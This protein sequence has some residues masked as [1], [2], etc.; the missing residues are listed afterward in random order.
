MPQGVQTP[1]FETITKKRLRDASKAVRALSHDGLRF[2]PDALH[3][4]RVALRRMRSVCKNFDAEHRILHKKTTRRIRRLAHT[5]NRARDMDIT[6]DWVQNT[7][8]RLTKRD[9]A[10]ADFLLAYL[11][12]EQQTIQMELQDTLQPYFKKLKKRVLHD[13]NSKRSRHQLSPA[14][15]ASRTEELLAEIKQGVMLYHKEYSSSSRATDKCIETLHQTRIV[16]KRIRYLLETPRPQSLTEGLIRDL[17]ILQDTLGTL[18]DRQIII[19]LIEPLLAPH[20]PAKKNGDPA[21]PQS[22]RQQGLKKLLI[23]AA[24]ER[25]HLLKEINPRWLEQHT[26]KIGRKLLVF[27]GKICADQL[28]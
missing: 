15:Y 9:Q 6:I 25:D 12:H 21:V 28:I 8:S 4:F 17:K 5:T 27:K 1:P 23:L 3:D 2:D 10:S 18:N 26:A 20:P 24:S 19:A 7:R 22:S 16:I 13:L 11:K 14:D